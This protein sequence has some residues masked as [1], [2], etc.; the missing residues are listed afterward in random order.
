MQSL[1]YVEKIFY[2]NDLR[3]IH[4]FI[5]ISNFIEKNNLIFTIGIS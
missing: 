3:K 5:N 4:F 2:K 1:I